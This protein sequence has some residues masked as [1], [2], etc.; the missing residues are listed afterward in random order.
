MWWGGGRGGGG[1]R[2]ETL[3]SVIRKKNLGQHRRLVW[4]YV[5]V[6]GRVCIS[7]PILYISVSENQPHLADVCI[8]FLS[9]LVSIKK[10]HSDQ[11]KMFRDNHLSCCLINTKAPSS[12]RFDFS[13]MSRHSSSV[14]RRRFKEP[15]GKHTD[16]GFTQRNIHLNFQ[17]MSCIHSKDNYRFSHP[18]VKLNGNTWTDADR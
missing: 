14:M 18:Q 13:L 16:A 6:W 15:A 8:D 17:L 2:G 5:S 3:F 9:P 1:G 10:S 7:A 12:T 4:I 11:V